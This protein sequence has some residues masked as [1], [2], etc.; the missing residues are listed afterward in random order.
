M[1][2]LQVSD[3]R[4]DSICKGAFNGLIAIEY[5]NLENNGLRYVLK[6][7]LEGDTPAKA[8]SIVLIKGNYTLNYLKH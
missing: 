4:I 6:N 3:N 8:P 1:N 5:I 7:T 2:I